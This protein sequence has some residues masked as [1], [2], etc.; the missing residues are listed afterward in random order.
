MNG[1]RVR[2]RASFGGRVSGLAEGWDVGM[3]A[4]RKPGQLPRFWLEQL[5]GLRPRS[6]RWE[7][8]GRKQKRG[9][10]GFTRSVGP[11]KL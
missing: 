10:T 3:R 11:F 6:R 1:G 8:L 7:T 4:E 2:S 5:S 9:R